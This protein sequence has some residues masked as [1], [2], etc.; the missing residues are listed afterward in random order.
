LKAAYSL[1]PSDDF[2]R[3]TTIQ[4]PSQIEAIPY[5]Y[6]RDTI[7]EPVSAGPENTC[8]RLVTILGPMAALR[9]QAAILAS[10]VTWLS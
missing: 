8:S 2:A 7:R 6:G 5:V 9:P 4:L 10:S 3:A 1:V